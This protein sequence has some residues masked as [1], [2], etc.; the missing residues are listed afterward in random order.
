MGDE[1][2]TERRNQTENENENENESGSESASKMT[3]PPPQ[4][5]PHALDGKHSNRPDPIAS[6]KL[7]RLR[8]NPRT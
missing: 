6:L 7:N 2:R 1:S 5:M 3:R 8:R 4:H